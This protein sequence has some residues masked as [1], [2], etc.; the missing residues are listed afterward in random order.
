MSE[1]DVA[2]Q[3]STIVTEGSSKNA[4]DDAPAAMD[5]SQD[6]QPRGLVTG[7]VE[8]PT[9][10]P[11][12]STANEPDLEGA[13]EAPKIKKDDDRRTMSRPPSL[14]HSNRRVIVQNV[15]K[16]EDTKGM[17]KTVNKWV[18]QM[19]ETMPDVAVEVD[20]VKK[21][22]KANWTV[23]T[24]KKES[25]CQPFID[26]INESDLVNKRG[27]H[28]V[29]KSALDQKRPAENMES[30]RFVPSKRQRMQS[31]TDAPARRAVTEEEIKDKIT[32]LWRLSVEEQQDVKMK[33]LIRKCTMKIVKDIKSRTR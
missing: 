8:K 25:M 11:V 28:L 16:F 4:A 5:T 33:E 21:P 14:D 3:P 6:Q 1:R 12:T 30:D 27:F 32:P 2:K 26:F 31:E 15:L 19:K 10:E 7:S 29:A 23:V 17:T 22:P 9:N 18:I 20:K 13:M 24:L